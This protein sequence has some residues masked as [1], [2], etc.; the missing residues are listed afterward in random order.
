M[1]L[2]NAI[3]EGFAR[4]VRSPGLVA[5]LWAVHLLA[6]LPFAAVLAG[7]IHDDVAERP[8]AHRLQAGYD[9]DWMGEFGAA[10]R[11]FESTF[12]PEVVGAGAFLRNLEAWWSGRLFTDPAGGWGLLAAGVGFALLWTFLLGGVLHRLARSGRGAE[13]GRPEERAGFAAACGRFFSRFLGLALLAAPFYLLIY[14]LARTGFGALEEA[15]RDVTSERTA[16]LWS[17][18]GALLVVLLLTLVKVVFDYA[19]I[20]VVV[21]GRRGVLAAAGAGLRF[22]LS[23]PLATLG[24]YWSFALATLL[25][26]RLYAA[27]A[28]QTGP[29]GWLGVVLALLLGQLAL[30]VRI[31]LRLAVLGGEAAMYREGVG[32]TAE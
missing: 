28:P 24:L 23:R 8:V 2:F 13:P 20:A 18:A 3:R 17:A 27:V 19:K 21:E 25:L 6:A 4:A 9:A 32:A 26:L 16:L 29:G 15:M 1:G 10:A 22:V 31:G 14:W 11:G 7:S 12:G 5:L 30:A